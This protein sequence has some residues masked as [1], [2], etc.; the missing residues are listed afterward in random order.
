[1]PLIVFLMLLSQ[2]YS[3]RGYVES[4]GVLYPG[5]AVNDSGHVIGEIHV[6]HES[7]FRPWTNFQL[8]GGI[9]VKMDSHHQTEREFRFDWQ[10]RSRKRP[11]LSLRRLSAQYHRAGLTLEAGKQFVRWGR[12]DIVNPTDRFA[13]RDFLTVVDN[14]FLGIEAVRGTYEQGS[15]TVDVIWSPRLTPAGLLCSRNAGSFLQPVRQPSWLSATS[16]KVRR[17]GF[18]GVMSASWNLQRRSIPVSITFLP[19]S[20]YP[21]ASWFEKPMRSNE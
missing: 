20:S 6:R 8:A 14:E 1:M 4:V 3:Q 11:L 12:T 19:T 21:E 10:D 15:N 7:F 9:D 17:P 18:A 5:S 16:R 13:P 2:D